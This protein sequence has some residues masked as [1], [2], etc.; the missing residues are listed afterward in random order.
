MSYT[1]EEAIASDTCALRARWARDD[2]DTRAA[3]F[4]RDA[5]GVF[6]EAL[7]RRID[8]EDAPVEVKR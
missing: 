2:G 6:T 7:M 1:S 8:L 3:G 4:W 5:C